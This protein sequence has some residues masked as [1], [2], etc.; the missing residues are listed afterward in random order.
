MLNNF[1]YASYYAIDTLTLTYSD[2]TWHVL[3]LDII[4]NHSHVLLEELGCT[5]M[6]VRLIRGAAPSR[7]GIAPGRRIQSSSC[8]GGWER[9]DRVMET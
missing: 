3:D 9:T 8:A 6:K 1:N 7:G 5:C 2:H 4:L